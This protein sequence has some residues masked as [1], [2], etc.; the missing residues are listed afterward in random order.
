MYRS[1]FECDTYA[2]QL[3]KLIKDYIRHFLNSMEELDY[4]LEQLRIKFILL[5]DF[6]C[7]SEPTNETEFF[8]IKYDRFYTWEVFSNLGLGVE[9]MIFLSRLT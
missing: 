8:D 2:D 7:C 4:S 6:S 9:Y 1:N 3:N 5:R